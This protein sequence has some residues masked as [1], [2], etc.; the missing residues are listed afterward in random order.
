MHDCYKMFHVGRCSTPNC[1]YVVKG[2][3]RLFATHPHKRHVCKPCLQEDPQ[4]H[5]EDDDVVLCS[6]QVKKALVGSNILSIGQLEQCTTGFMYNTYAQELAPLAILDAVM[7]L[8]S[9]VSLYTI[10]KPLSHVTVCHWVFV[11][12]LLSVVSSELHSPDRIGQ[13]GKKDQR[14]S[15]NSGP[16]LYRRVSATR[17]MYNNL[18][19]TTLILFQLQTACQSVVLENVKTSIM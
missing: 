8:Y 5:A 7:N 17:A 18:K 4:L 15:S 9:Y 2:I 12:W 19:Y 3:N 13:Q 14:P 1:I 6:V 16:T 11:S 10:C